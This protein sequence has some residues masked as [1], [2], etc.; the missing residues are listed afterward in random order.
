MTGFRTKFML[1]VAMVAMAVPG[2]AQ[3]RRPPTIMVGQ[4]IQSDVP[5][6]R[7]GECSPSD[8]RVKSWRLTAAE[9]DRLE[10]T[11]AADDFDTVV[12]IGRMDGCVYHQLGTNVDGTGEEDGLNSRLIFS[13]LKA[14]DYVV[15]ARSLADDG[16]GPFTIALNRLGVLPPPPT[17]VALTLGEAVSAVMATNDPVIIDGYDG[18][19]M[20]A[21]PEGDY[22][23][24]ADTSGYIQVQEAGRP[25]HYYTLTGQAGQ[26]YLIKMDSDEFDPYLDAGILSPLGYSVALS[27]DDG[28]GEED[29]LNS[30]L[31]VKFQSDGTIVIRA[32]PLGPD[33]GKYTLSAGI[34]PP[35]EVVDAAES[36]AEAAADAAAMPHEH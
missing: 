34:A 32:S 24:M 17:P 5:A 9:G 12:E 19:A 23:D 20:A 16:A 15:R 14:G 4:S 30:R 8:P 22:G 21:M 18:S 6:A 27:N 28:G 3:N 29:G 25:Y 26:E 2:A 1:G 7:S 10:L 36:A 11:M 35:E 13:V 31:R 33:T